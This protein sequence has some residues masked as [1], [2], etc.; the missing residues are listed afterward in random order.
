V[1]AVS[2]QA[3]RSSYVALACLGALGAILLHSL[4]DFNLYI[5]ANAT[6]AA[7]VAGLALAPQPLRSART[8]ACRVETHLDACAGKSAGTAG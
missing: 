3:A 2:S 4:V 1:V 5:P 6:V 7:W 8:P